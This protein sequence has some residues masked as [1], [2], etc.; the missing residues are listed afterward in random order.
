MKY[1]LT[2]LFILLGLF[3]VRTEANVQPLNPEKWESL[4]KNLDY[5][6]EPP[7]QIE[8]PKANGPF[9]EFLGKVFSLL[10][11]I[12]LTALVGFI[13]YY[14]ISRYK[15]PE[16]KIAKIKSEITAAEENPVEAD[17]DELLQKAEKTGNSRLILRIYYLMVIKSLAIK[18]HIRHAPR[19]TNRDYLYEI[20][21]AE[22]KLLFTDLTYAFDQIWYGGITISNE[23]FNRRKS[24]SLSLLETVNTLKG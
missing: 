5:S 6:E 3:L 22:I 19:K 12:T 20:K 1:K 16:K 9:L 14:L 15:G 23:E 13:A 2:I 10:P 8:P 18:K 11:Y 24:Q 17:L 7:K 4:T 21:N